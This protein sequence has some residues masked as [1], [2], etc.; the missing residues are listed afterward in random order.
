LRFLFLIL[1]QIITVSMSY[2]SESDLERLQ[3]AYIQKIINYVEWPSSTSDQFII[4]VY[5]NDKL[6]QSISDTFNEKVINGKIVNVVKDDK[7][8]KAS[9]VCAHHSDKFK[10]LP[11]DGVLFITDDASGLNGK[12]ILNFFQEG[13]KLRFD[14][15]QTQ[16]NESKIK[17]NS[18]LLKLSRSL[19]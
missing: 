15:N 3:T 6:F 9:I 16:A 7:N 14:I 17:I 11:V 12:S 4:A 19:K 8:V 5:D 13:G 18:R 10:S 2:G 1:I